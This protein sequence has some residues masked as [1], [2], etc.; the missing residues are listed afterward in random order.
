MGGQSAATVGDR[1]RRGSGEERRGD[2]P[3]ERPQRCA[4]LAVTGDVALRS[5]HFREGRTGH[6]PLI[7]PRFIG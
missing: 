1:R 2:N 4:R 7:G 6:T 5:L 3:V